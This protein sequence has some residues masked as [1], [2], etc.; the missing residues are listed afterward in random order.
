MASNSSSYYLLSRC[1]VLDSCQPKEKMNI[2]SRQHFLVSSRPPAT[3]F[4]RV[5]C[6]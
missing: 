4:L 3:S 5:N 2:L 1:Y 6:M